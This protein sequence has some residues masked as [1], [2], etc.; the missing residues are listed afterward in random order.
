MGGKGKR[1]ISFPPPPLYQTRGWAA[2]VDS[3]SE[4]L[5]RV[6]AF[7]AVSVQPDSG[8]AG[9]QRGGRGAV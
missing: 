6:T 2:I 7:A 3:V 9:D 5:R 4:Q 1:L 8:T